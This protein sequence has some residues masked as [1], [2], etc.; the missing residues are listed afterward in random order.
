MKPKNGFFRAS[1]AFLLFCGFLST[2]CGQG[3]EPSSTDLPIAEDSTD[4]SGRD[5][6]AP[7]VVVDPTGRAWREGPKIENQWPDDPRLD[8]A[9][10]LIRSRKFADAETVLGAILQDRPEIGRARF[11]RG[12]AI[13]KQKRYEAALEEIDAAMATG[14][15]FPEAAHAGHF[16]GWCL[17]H[18]GRLEPAAEAFAAHA[19]EFPEEGDTQFGLGVV[20]IDQGRYEEAEVFLNRAIEL[21]ADIPERRR[22]LAKAHA[23]LGDAHLG[24]DRLD[25]ARASYHTAVIQWPDHYEAWAKL[26]R[27]LDRLDRPVEAERARAEEANARRRSGRFIESPIDSAGEVGR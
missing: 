13:Q 1:G 26:A 12:L 8:A 17:Y 27:A 6:A 9:R 4:V 23:R 10:S 16:R 18:L 19:R 14:Q 7:V 25:E 20:A 2:G 11:L 22:E 15:R 3:D 21:Q 5:Q 24:L